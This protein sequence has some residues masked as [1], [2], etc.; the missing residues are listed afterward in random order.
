MTR[1][2][3]GYVELPSGEV[4]RGVVVYL[5]GAGGAE[6]SGATPSELGNLWFDALNAGWACMSIRSL[7]GE[8]WQIEDATPN[9]APTEA[10]RVAMEAAAWGD[11]VAAGKPR[12]YVGVSQGASVA[13]EAAVLD[14]GATGVAMLIGRGRI[15]P[16][17]RVRPQRGFRVFYAYGGRD[18]VGE[19]GP[20][21]RLG[22]Y[23]DR[24]VELD[25]LE[26]AG[27]IVLYRDPDRREHG[28]DSRWLDASGTDVGFYLPALRHNLNEPA[29][30]AWTA[31]LRFLGIADLADK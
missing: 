17:Q 4:P 31:L 24:A 3:R 18:A 13:T 11:A 19:M 27:R 16:L 22:L 20:E 6:I 21:E 1:I 25:G 23:I 28:D 7:D 29:Q 26:Q 2:S 30:K 14:E 10:R 9:T 12:V 8:A 15:A 5:H